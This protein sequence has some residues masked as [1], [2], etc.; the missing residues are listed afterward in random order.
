[1]CAVDADGPRR[2]REEAGNQIEQGRFARAAGAA[3]GGDL[4]GV[5]LHGEVVGAAPAVA[6]GDARQARARLSLSNRAGRAMKAAMVRTSM[7]AA[8]AAASL[9]R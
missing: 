8:I 5:R 9:V 2:W 6:E 3:D 7:S 1:M 4:A